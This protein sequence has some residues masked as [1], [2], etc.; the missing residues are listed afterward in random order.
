MFLAMHLRP[1]CTHCAN[2]CMSETCHV[3]QGNVQVKCLDMHQDSHSPLC[4]PLFAPALP[5]QAQLGRHACTMILAVSQR[6]VAWLPTWLQPH[7][8]SHHHISRS[9]IGYVFGHNRPTL[10][11][12]SCV[13]KHHAALRDVRV[14]S[15]AVLLLMAIGTQGPGCGRAWQTC[16]PAAL[17][18]RLRRA[19][20][21][22]QVEVRPYRMVVC[23]T[24]PTQCVPTYTSCATDLPVQQGDAVLTT[25][26]LTAKGHLEQRCCHEPCTRASRLSGAAAACTMTLES[27]G[28]SSERYS[29]PASNRS[30]RVS[31][32]GLQCVEMH[33]SMFDGMNPELAANPQPQDPAPLRRSP[34]TLRT[35]QGCI[36][37]RSRRAAPAAEEV[38][39]PHERATACPPVLWLHDLA[40]VR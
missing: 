6:A 1:A 25:A 35:P 19:A 31:A 7:L 18:L 12:A 23:G 2:H 34:R 30:D 4:F 16:A 24:S 13:W 22:V 17:Q 3:Q 10:Q 32:S 39:Q 36:G 20:V 29:Q 9:D 27:A 26:D 38:P 5:D 33:R 11:S 14:A 8:K 21:R 15:N 37:A 40:C 28:V